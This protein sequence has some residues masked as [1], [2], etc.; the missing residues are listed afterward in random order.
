MRRKKKEGGEREGEKEG[1]RDRK[2]FSLEKTQTILITESSISGGLVVNSKDEVLVVKE[3][4]HLGYPLW[5]FP[6]GYAMKG[7]ELGDTAV[8]EVLEE[9]GIRTKFDFMIA[10]RHSHRFQFECS[11]MYFVAFLRP[12]EEGSLTPVRGLHE[13]SDVTWMKHQEL[14]PQLSPFNSFILQQ[15]LRIRDN[16]VQMRCQKMDTIIGSVNVYFVGTSSSEDSS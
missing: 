16:Q 5:K 3:K 9:T 2:D 11:D 13:I 6:G 14:A 10:L 4:Y 7:E 12:D 8:R 1:T 15:Y